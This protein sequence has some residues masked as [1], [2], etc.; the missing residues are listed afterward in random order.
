MPV[1]PVALSTRG[2]MAPSPT[3]VSTYPP[4]PHTQDGASGFSFWAWLDG[5]L[6]LLQE[7][8]KQL[9]KNG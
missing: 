1:P 3:L 2:P 7:H 5:I 4:P 9:W 8:L 6:G